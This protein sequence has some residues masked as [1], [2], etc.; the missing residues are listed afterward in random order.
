MSDKILNIKVIPNAKVNKIS[1]ED[2]VFKIKI[3]A[4]AHEGKANKALIKFLSEHFG[5]PK[6]K[7]KIISGE[8]AR[9][10]KVRLAGS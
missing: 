10:K 3:C 5:V 8:K 7:I 9:D 1:A 6:S 4:P 2:G